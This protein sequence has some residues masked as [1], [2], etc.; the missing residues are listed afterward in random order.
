MYPNMRVSDI[1]D[2]VSKEWDVGLL[3]NYVS[4]E[5]IPLI[6]SLAISST[7][8]RDTFCWNYTRN[9]Q[10]TW[11]RLGMDGQCWEHSTYGNKEFHSTQISLSFGN[12]STA[13]GDGEY[14]STLNMSELRDRLQRADCNDK[15]PS[16]LAKFYDRIGE[17]RDVTDTLPGLQHHSCS[18]GAQS[19]YKFFI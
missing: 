14:A 8:R 17:D 13:V 2:H 9:D 11:M 18:T 7:H 16:G 5:D 10:Y 19:D 4:L 12:R 15:G 6:R 3:E 1:I